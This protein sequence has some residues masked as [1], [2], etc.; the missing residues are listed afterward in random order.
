M[1]KNDC[2]AVCRSYLNDLQTMIEQNDFETFNEW[3]GNNVL[4]YEFIIGSNKSLLAANIYL[5]L[6]GPTVWI[7]TSGLGHIIYRWGDEKC[8]IMLN[9]TVRDFLNDYMEEVYNY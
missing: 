6:G 9:S 8:D 1:S 2:Y 7:D 3:F 5:E 4:D